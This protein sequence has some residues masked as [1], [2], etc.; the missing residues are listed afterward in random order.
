VDVE[1]QTVPHAL[2][3]VRIL[4]DKERGMILSEI[5]KYLMKHKRV[6][7]GD[8]ACHFDSEPEAMKG[9]LGQWIRKG[10]VLKLDGQAGCS[11]TCGKCCDGAAMEIYE[12]KH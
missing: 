7:L 8:L 4:L 1:K 11:K 6:T 5:K 2:E 3:R 10:K 9:M 12:W